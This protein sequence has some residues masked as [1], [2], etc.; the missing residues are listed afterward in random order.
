M[1]APWIGSYVYQVGKYGEMG[2]AL[3][4]DTKWRGA[5]KTVA[6]SILAWVLWVQMRAPKTPHAALLSLLAGYFAYFTFNA[7]VHENHVFIPMMIGL[8]M[9][10]GVDPAGWGWRRHR[11]LVLAA[12]VVAF[13]HLN[14]LLFFEFSG[15]DRAPILI[16]GPT[17]LDVSVPLSLVSIVIFVLAVR[18]L[19][20]T[21]RD[22]SVR[23]RPA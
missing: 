2:P 1:N 10:F 16:G 23:A 14:P 13:A 8:V 5:I 22:S 18:Y 4:R 15:R 6:A 12:A 11:H 9:A 7:G 21:G 19:R 3:V 17:G 20:V